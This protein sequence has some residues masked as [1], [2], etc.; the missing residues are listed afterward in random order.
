MSS[1]YTDELYELEDVLLKRDAQDGDGNKHAA[2]TALLDLINRPSLFKLFDISLLHADDHALLL[3]ITKVLSQ[4]TLPLSSKCILMLLIRRLTAVLCPHTTQVP[5]CRSLLD[6]HLNYCELIQRVIIK[7]HPQPSWKRLLKE[8]MVSDLNHTHLFDGSVGVVHDVQLLLNAIV[9]AMHQVDADLVSLKDLILQSRQYEKWF[10][11]HQVTY[12]LFGDW[13]VLHFISSAS[14]SNPSSTGGKR[15]Q[16]HQ[17]NLDVF[18]HL[19]SVYGCSVLSCDKLGRSPLHVAASCLNHSVALYITETFPST[20]RI[21]DHRGEPA[22][23][24]LLLSWLLC[25]QRVKALSSGIICT[26]SM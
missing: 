24:G 17:S 22:L 1:R 9:D 25:C 13:T 21:H 12:P 19:T 3:M 14:S 20:V 26:P 6:W 5:S 15:H 11:F 2:F 10:S 7:C 8:L 23:S 16:Y 18:K 4:H